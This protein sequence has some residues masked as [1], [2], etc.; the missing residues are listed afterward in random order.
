MFV[1]EIRSDLHLRRMEKF[2]TVN[3]VLYRTRTATDIPWMARPPLFLFTN[4]KATV[5]HQSVI[6][7]EFYSRFHKTE[8]GRPLP[9]NR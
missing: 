6:P 5:A 9:I 4:R 1:K 8:K 3:S 2:S 7:L